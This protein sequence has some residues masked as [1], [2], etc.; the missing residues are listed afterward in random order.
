MDGRP[1]SHST[2]HSRKP[3]MANDASSGSYR[4][5]TLGG[6]LILFGTLITLVAIVSSFLVL[7]VTIR[8]QTRTHLVELLAQN[9]TN[10]RDLQERSLQELLWNST[11]MSQSPTL[12]AALDTYRSESNADSSH[13]QDLL[14][15][16]NTE[17]RK[18][19]EL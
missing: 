1:R 14:A 12:R 7:S 4:A 3:R 9:Q 8:R 17:V 15:T 2:S 5:P 13:R 16:V 18:I 19:R 10:A 11:L 6:R